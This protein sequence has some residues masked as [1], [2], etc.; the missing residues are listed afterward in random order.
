MKIILQPSNKYCY[1][2]IQDKEK[3]LCQTCW[4]L[5][6]FAPNQPEQNKW[7]LCFLLHHL[8]S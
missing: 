5:K 8:S 1:G 6:D 3:P 2:Q 4:L 7:Y